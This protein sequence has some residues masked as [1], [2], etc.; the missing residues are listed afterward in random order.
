MTMLGL[1]LIHRTDS[2]G[3]R[4]YYR[5]RDANWEQAY[6]MTRLPFLH[7]HG[8]TYTTPTHA[9]YTYPGPLTTAM[10]QG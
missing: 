5:Y 6:V 7:S 3:R 9:I 4:Y 2:A 10:E 8:R 1:H